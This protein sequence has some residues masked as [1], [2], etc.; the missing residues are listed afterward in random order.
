MGRNNPYRIEMI[1]ESYQDTIFKLENLFESI[2]DDIKNFTLEV[3]KAYEVLEDNR[4]IN[5]RK[6]NNYVMNLEY[7]QEQLQEKLLMLDQ[8]RVALAAVKKAHNQL[9]K[10]YTESYLVTMKKERDKW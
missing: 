5:A 6:I 9:V 4:L 3:E 8:T 10:Y 1:I 7:A 2:D